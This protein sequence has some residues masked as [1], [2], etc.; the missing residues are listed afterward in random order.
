MPQSEFHVELIA[1][2]NIRRML[3]LVGPWLR[4]VIDRSEGIMGRFELLERLERGNAQLWI[5]TPDGAKLQM[6]MVTS[7]VTYPGVK[8]LR[9]ELLKGAGL[10]DI[11]FYLDYV[12][13]WATQFGVTETEAWVQPGLRKML[14]PHRFQKKAEIIVRP[15]LK[16]QH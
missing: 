8:R 1:K 11:V 9:I 12:E 6:I 5:G 2:E 3:P 7:I 13:N 4:E 16:G 14:T 15:I 10:R